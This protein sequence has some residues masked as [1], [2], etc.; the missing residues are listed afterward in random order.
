M[1]VG[2]SQFG[3]KTIYINRKSHWKVTKLQSNFKLNLDKVNRALNNRTSSLV[4]RTSNVSKA[5]AFLSISVTRKRAKGGRWRVR[6]GSGEKNEHKPNPC[7]QLASFYILQFIP[8]SLP[9]SWIKRKQIICEK[10]NRQRTWNA[11]YI[12]FK[13]DQLRFPTHR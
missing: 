2:Q 9:P 11:L 7:A 1:V 8:A 12:N 3:T 10:T 13:Y 4:K 5:V 6:Y